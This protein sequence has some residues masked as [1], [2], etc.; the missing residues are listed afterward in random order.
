MGQALGLPLL[1]LIILLSVAQRAVAGEDFVSSW[2]NNNPLIDQF[3][4]HALCIE[5]KSYYVNTS[6]ARSQSCPKNT[7]RFETWTAA[8]YRQKKYSN[9]FQ[10]ALRRV[11]QT[12]KSKYLYLP[13]ANVEYHIKPG[14]EV[15]KTNEVHPRKVVG[16]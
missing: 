15:M 13:T 4:K 10:Y 5:S 14:P 11:R 12:D 3:G 2:G 16:K 8:Q 6:D 9:N 1:P 7:C